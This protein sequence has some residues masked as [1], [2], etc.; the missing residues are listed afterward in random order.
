MGTDCSNAAPLLRPFTDFDGPRKGKGRLDG[1]RPSVLAHRQAAARGL[2]H[3]AGPDVGLEASGSGAP[4]SGAGD[5]G[6]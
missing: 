2:A 6:P 5:A 4:L 1:L 3:R